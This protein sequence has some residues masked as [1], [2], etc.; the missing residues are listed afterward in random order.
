MALR[1]RSRGGIVGSLS[2]QPRVE[3]SGNTI[4]EDASVGDLIGTLSVVNGSGSYTFTL[5]VGDSLFDIDGDDLEVG[6]ALSVGIESITVEADNGVDDPV[7]GIFSIEITEVAVEGY[8]ADT[9][10]YTA[11]SSLIT[12]DA[13]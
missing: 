3:L 2:A 10:V 8:T 11:D 12:A 6:A 1:S 5:T 13:A 7:V 4:A 9:T